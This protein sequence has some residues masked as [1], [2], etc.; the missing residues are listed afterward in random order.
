[1]TTKDKILAYSTP[2]PNTGCWLWDRAVS[3]GGYA[4]MR[5]RGRL[6]GAHRVA[7]VVFVG[8][9]GDLD[10]CHKC[11]TPSC[12]NPNHIYAG[13]HTDNM[14]DKVTRGRANVRRGDLHPSRLYPERRPKGDGH[15]ARQRPERLSR[16]DAHYCAKLSTDKVCDIRRRAAM[17]ES[18]AALAREYGVA[19]TVAFNAGVGKTWRSAP[20]APCMR[21]RRT[22]EPLC[23]SGSA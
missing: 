9:L 13:T 18:Y 15:Y 21:G 8:D 22:Y 11:D 14:R 16:G 10:A 23:T 12:V 6:T 1:M 2:E 19:K 7:Y 5:F 17:G 20:C 4:R 3:R